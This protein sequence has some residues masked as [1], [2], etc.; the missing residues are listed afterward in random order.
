MPKWNTQRMM[1]YD[2]MIYRVTGNRFFFGG[3]KGLD[4]YEKE[5]YDFYRTVP[6]RTVPYR[7]VPCYS[8][9]LRITAAFFRVE[10]DI[11]F[12][13]DNRRI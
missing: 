2:I 3:G 7:T 12:V 5:A 8:T 13:I 10:Q 11:T 9:L 4:S 6:Y 1:F